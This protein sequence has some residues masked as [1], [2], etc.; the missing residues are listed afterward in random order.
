MSDKVKKFVPAAAIGIMLLLLLAVHLIFSG[1]SLD[2][3]KKTTETPVAAEAEQLVQTAIKYIQNDDMK[4]L[5]GL[6]YSNDYGL[7]VSN[8][9]RGLF[10][11]K[12]FAPVKFTGRNRKVAKSTTENVLVEVHS[13]KRQ[14]NY[15]IS[16][17]KRKGEWRV[18]GISSFELPN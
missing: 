1:D 10:A 4:A 7:F 14:K 5:F 16:M 6:M 17:V 8:Y 9:E 2:D 11:E 13:E 15:W 18:A 12:D 3:Y